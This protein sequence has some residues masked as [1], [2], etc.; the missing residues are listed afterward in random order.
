MS[1]ER[2]KPYP[3]DQIEPKCQAIWDERQPFHAPNPGKKGFDP[4][5]PKFYILTCFLTRAGP[6]CTSAIP[7]VTPP[8][9]LLPAT[10]GCATS[11]SCIRWVGTHSV[12][13]PSN[14]P[15]KAG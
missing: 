13:P 7:K 11:T 10:N 6:G 12:C 4:T 5:K 14:T 15:S 3:F 9:T 2:R 1:S 8:R